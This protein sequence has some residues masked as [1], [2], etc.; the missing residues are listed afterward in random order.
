MMPRIPPEMITHDLRRHRDRDED[1]VDREHD[2]VSST[3]TTVAQKAESPIHAWPACG[4]RG[5]AVAAAEEML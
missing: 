3:L 4:A 5:S 2:V 1:R